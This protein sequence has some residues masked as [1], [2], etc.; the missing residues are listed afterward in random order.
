[1]PETSPS[2]LVAEMAHLGATSA[3]FM[4]QLL[5]VD[6]R[7]RCHEHLPQFVVHHSSN[8]F[9]NERLLTDPNL[10]YVAGSV[11]ELLSL[12]PP[13]VLCSYYEHL[14]KG[15]RHIRR[16]FETIMLSLD[17]HMAFY[18]SPFRSSTKASIIAMTV[19]GDL[20]SRG[21]LVIGGH[22]NLRIFS[23]IAYHIWTRHGG[24]TE[25]QRNSDPWMDDERSSSA[26]LLS[27][28]RH[29]RGRHYFILHCNQL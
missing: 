10:T 24:S 16:L 15:T 25:R 8:F 2:L 20:L 4:A 21:S 22:A 14:P 5:A 26:F 13:G 3:P 12:L 19:L 17:H 9:R 28:L 29:T 27:F 6:W 7:L 1:M 18:P 11:L 23:S